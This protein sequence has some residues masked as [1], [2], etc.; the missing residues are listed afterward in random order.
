M[1]PSPTSD[2]RCGNLQ[3]LPR[4][5]QNDVQGR[6]KGALTSVELKTIF[7]FAT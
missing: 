5:S 6:L 7:N 2:P 1:M 4:A 3:R